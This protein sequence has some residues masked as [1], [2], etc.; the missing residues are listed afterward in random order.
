MAS[1]QVKTPLKRALKVKE[2]VYEKV[3]FVG[4]VIGVDVRPRR[5]ARPLGCR[6]RLPDDHVETA[7][8]TGRDA[9]DEI[10]GGRILHGQLQL[11]STSDFSLF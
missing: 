9:I 5:G 8:E 1:T 6:R 3:R 2:F 7:R 4:D 11:L 10:G